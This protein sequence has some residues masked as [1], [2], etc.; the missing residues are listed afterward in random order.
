MPPPTLFLE[1]VF[2]ETALTVRA[3]WSACHY[4]LSAPSCLAASLFKVSRIR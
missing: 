4:L 3:D 2:L 1:T